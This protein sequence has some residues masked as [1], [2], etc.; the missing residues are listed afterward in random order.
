MQE[1][2][3]I[4]VGSCVGRKMMGMK[5]DGAKVRQTSESCYELLHLKKH[6]DQ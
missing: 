2:G 3:K 4:V 6:G 5:E 1:Q